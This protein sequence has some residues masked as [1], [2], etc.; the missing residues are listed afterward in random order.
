MQM[1]LTTFAVDYEAGLFSNFPRE[2]YSAFIEHRPAGVFEKK[3]LFYVWFIN[4]SGKTQNLN[5]RD[6]SYF[7]HDSSH[8]F[9]QR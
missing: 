7:L 4:N 3:T 8:P 2:K 1:K 9:A 5:C 6:K